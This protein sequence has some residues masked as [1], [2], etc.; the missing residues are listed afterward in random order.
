[1]NKSIRSYCKIFFSHLSNINHARNIKKQS[2]I[3]KKINRNFLGILSHKIHTQGGENSKKAIETHGKRG[4]YSRTGKR[5]KK[6]LGLALG[7]GKV[8]GLWFE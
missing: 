6:T 7:M 4:A 5:D 8:H 3:I 1:L 2:K